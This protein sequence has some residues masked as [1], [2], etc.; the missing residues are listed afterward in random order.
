MGIVILTTMSQA[1][2]VM[3]AGTGEWSSMSTALLGMLPLSP[4]AI[5]IDAIH[6]DGDLTMACWEA[7]LVAVW[8]FGWCWSMKLYIHMY[9]VNSNSSYNSMFCVI[10][11]LFIRTAGK[12]VISFMFIHC[13][14][15]VYT[16]LHTVLSFQVCAARLQKGHNTGGILWYLSLWAAPRTH[17][18]DLVTQCLR[19]SATSRLCLLGWSNVALSRNMFLPCLVSMKTTLW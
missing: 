4:A 10:G 7:G 16:W 2:I 8:Y 3:R 6:I 18:C 5:H 12:R 13:T 1:Q 11:W 15:D 14:G 9:I 17:M 19:P